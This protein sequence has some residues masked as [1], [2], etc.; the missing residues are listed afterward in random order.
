MTEIC[1][2]EK[3][4]KKEERRNQVEQNSVFSNFWFGTL[5]NTNVHF[6][7][8]GWFRRVSV[9]C[10]LYKRILDAGKAELE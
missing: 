1:L 10:V 3:E 5:D 8:I 9:V 4:R 6:D 2:L 7:Q